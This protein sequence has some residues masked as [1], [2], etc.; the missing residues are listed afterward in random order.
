MGAA[1]RS[2]PSTLFLSQ[3]D[4]C[5]EAGQNLPF[6][7]KRLCR[8]SSGVNAALGLEKEE[9][10]FAASTLKPQEPFCREETPLTSLS[11]SRYPA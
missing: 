5:F 10:L 11:V 4:L 2:H 6:A 7:E 1:L 3:K 8:H 9:E